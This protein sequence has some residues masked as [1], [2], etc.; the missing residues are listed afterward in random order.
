MEDLGVLFH[1]AGHT[2]GVEKECAVIVV[3]NG[4]AQAIG[5]VAEVVVHVA[6]DDEGNV[7]AKGDRLV[8]G[9]GKIR[10]TVVAADRIPV[11]AAGVFGL[12]AHAGGAGV[13]EKN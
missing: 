7:F 5:S 1:N 3:V 13:T 11:L 6:E 10:I 4:A 8:N 9:G 2:G 12:I